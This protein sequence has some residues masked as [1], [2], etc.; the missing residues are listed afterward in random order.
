M[1]TFYVLA[2]DELVD[3]VAVITIGGEL[4]YAVT[5]QLREHMYGRIAAGHRRLLLDFSAVTF[6]D[7]TAIGVIVG[8]VS[9]LRASGGGAVAVV[10]G[11]EATALDGTEDFNSVRQ[12]FQIAGV[13]A[14]V[15]LCSSREEAL[16]LLTAVP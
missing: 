15:E 3:E 7:S 14:A 6:I 12:I 2:D 8:A 1:S 10:C 16:S 11:G 9:R 13:D 5:P 4:D